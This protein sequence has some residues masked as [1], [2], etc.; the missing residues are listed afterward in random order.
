MAGPSGGACPDVAK[1]NL[2]YAN[3]IASPAAARP[4]ASVAPPVR[5]RSCPSKPPPASPWRRA[6][7]FNSITDRTG[8]PVRDLRVQPRHGRNHRNALTDVY[9]CALA[10]EH[11]PAILPIA[12]LV[13]I[14]NV[15]VAGTIALPACWNQTI[16]KHPTRT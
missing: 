10:V 6:C 14:N 13:D 1:G 16:A 15:L 11:R 7:R 3:L 8:P 2:A 5:D 12:H 9:I 4:V